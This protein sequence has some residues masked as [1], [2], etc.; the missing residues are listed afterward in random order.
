MLRAKRIQ[1]PAA[2]LLAGLVVTAGYAQPP[3]NPGAP[4][5]TQSQS[6]TKYEP[7]RELGGKALSLWVRDL[8]SKDP[9][10][11]ALAV[12]TIP[13]F[14]PPAV[15][16]LPKII[17]KINEDQELNVRVAVLQVLT[18]NPI[19]EKYHP[20]IVKRIMANDGPINSQHV[21][22]RCQVALALVVIGPEARSA[23]DKLCG[24]EYLQYPHSFELRKASAAAL[25]Q[26]ARYDPKIAAKVKPG[27]PQ[28]TGPDVKAIIALI[29]RL[30]DPALE[31]RAEIAQALMYLGPPTKPEDVAKE[32][33]LIDRRLKTLKRDDSQFTKADETAAIRL[34]LRACLM[35]ISETEF[36]NQM[37]EIVRGLRG[38]DQEGRMTAAEILGM[39]GPN[40]AKQA[41]ELLRACKEAV[42]STKDEDLQFL[43]MC[44]WALGN[45]GT[46]ASFAAPDLEQIAKMHPNIDIKQRADLAYKLVKGM[47]I[48]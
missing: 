25:G 43:G 32:K 42:K 26:I 6:Q 24:E 46:K 19:E 17:K 38:E 18:M 37:P 39:F 16:A 34:W 1:T 28:P 27:Q 7:P 12:R 40:C 41:S 44:L 21:N 2:V 36:N 11:R 13:L 8:D 45:I 30:T 20:E 3:A 14:G 31:V 48:R 22:L 10:L 9:S 29:N 5:M 35:R 47:A 23:I 33:E 4:A 15:D